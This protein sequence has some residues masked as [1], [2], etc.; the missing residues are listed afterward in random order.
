MPA[1]TLDQIKA[2][3]DTNNSLSLSTSAVAEWK[4]IRNIVAAAIWSFENIFYLLKSQIDDTLAKK[5]PGTLS[6]YADKVKLFQTTGNLI[7]DANGLIIYDIVDTAKR[8]VSNVSVKETTE[9]NVVIKVAKKDNSGNLI[10]LTSEELLALNQYLTKVKYA[11]T[12]LSATSVNADIVKYTLIVYYDASYNLIAL[13]TAVSAAIAS[14]KSQLPFDGLF[15]STQFVQAITS[16][17]GV[18]TVKI[19]LLQGKSAAGSYADINP[20]YELVAGYF[21]YDNASAITYTAL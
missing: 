19:N 2:E 11:G 7:V 13:Q 9:G 10:A 16:V 8:I 21:N 5:Q 4:L 20:T 6:W 15:R 18:S 14:F 1:R 3:I 12:R 17:A